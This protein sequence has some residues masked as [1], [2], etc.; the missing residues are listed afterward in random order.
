MDSAQRRP[1]LLTTPR[2]KLE[3]R[4]IGTPTTRALHKW[5]HC[6]LKYVG[7][8]EAVVA[9]RDLHGNSAAH[10]LAFLPSL[11]ILTTWT[12][13]PVSRYSHCHIP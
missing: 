12:C 5:K 3:Q 8:K 6:V 2:P 10:R 13:G 9:I 1:A 7:R 11:H 4:E